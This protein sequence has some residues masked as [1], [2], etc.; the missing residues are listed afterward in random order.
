MTGF[1]LALSALFVFFRDLSYLWGIIGFILWMTSPVFYPTALVPERVRPWLELNPIGLAIAALREV[2]LGR[3]NI[4][5]ALVGA[6]VAVGLFTLAIGHLTFHALRG[7][8][9]DL[10]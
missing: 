9:M 4:D 3:G 2:S 1:G 5:Y 8:F 10:L 6:S 7:Q